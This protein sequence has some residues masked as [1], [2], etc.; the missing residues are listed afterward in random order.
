[1]AL[2]AWLQSWR[3]LSNYTLTFDLLLFSS[4]SLLSFG[5]TL[6]GFVFVV[7]ADGKVMYIS[8]TASTHLGLS[9]VSLDL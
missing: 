1:L 2:L 3:I 5:Q 6:D 8:E 9:Q 7:S 4:L